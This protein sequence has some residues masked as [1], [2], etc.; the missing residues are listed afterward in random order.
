MPDDSAGR[1]SG[2]LVLFGKTSLL[3]TE[4]SLERYIVASGERF[5][6]PVFANRAILAELLVQLLAI[7]ADK[8]ADTPQ[9]YQPSAGCTIRASHVALANT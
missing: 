7:D 4:Y 2:A 5:W 6:G 3:K 1:Y 8:S 9:A